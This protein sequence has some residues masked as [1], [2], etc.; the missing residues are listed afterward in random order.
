VAVLGAFVPSRFEVVEGKAAHVSTVKP[1][2]LTERAHAVV[3]AKAHIGL[4]LTTSSNGFQGRLSEEAINKR[5]CRHLIDHQ[6]VVSRKRYPEA[7]EVREI[8]QAVA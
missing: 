5:C 4:L 1:N 7:S 2:E 3:I 8:C 6:S